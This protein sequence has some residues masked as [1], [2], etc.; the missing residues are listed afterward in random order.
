[1][2]SHSRTRPALHYPIFLAGTLFICLVPGLLSA[3]AQADLSWKPS[4]PNFTNDGNWFNGNNWTALSTPTPTPA[5]DDDAG[6]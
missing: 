5:V 4:N 6:I 3:Q 2:R 1:M